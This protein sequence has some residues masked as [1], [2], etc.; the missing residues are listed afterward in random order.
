MYV[1][2]YSCHPAESMIDTKRH[3]ICMHLA[4]E[5]RKIICWLKIRW[6]TL[7]MH[8]RQYWF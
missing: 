1:P 3:F 6:E 8:H 2:K 4:K 7:I 5:E